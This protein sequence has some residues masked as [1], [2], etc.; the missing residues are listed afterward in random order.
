[1]Q[2]IYRYVHTPKK[3]FPILMILWSI[4]KKNLDVLFY[5]FKRI[6]LP[7]SLTTVYWITVNYKYFPQQY[8][9]QELIFLLQKRTKQNM[10]AV[11]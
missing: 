3:N 9:K 8:Q 4:R 7:Y 11:M 2:A 6:V 10:I 5:M 1:M